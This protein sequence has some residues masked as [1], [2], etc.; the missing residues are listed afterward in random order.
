[1]LTVCLQRLCPQ[2]SLE[3][4]PAAL[5][6]NEETPKT[7]PKVDPTWPDLGP[8]LASKLVKIRLLGPPGGLLGASWG[9]LGSLGRPWAPP[10]AAPGRRSEALRT[11]LGPTWAQLGANLR[12]TW[13]QKQ[14]PRTTFWTMFCCLA[15]RGQK[16]PNKL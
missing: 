2:A 11:V 3:T 13:L 14:P 15:L 8:V 9:L 10:G 7:Q 5:C 4:T 1:M 6:M 16:V 12:A